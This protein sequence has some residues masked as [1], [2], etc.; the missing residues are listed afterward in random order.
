M[1]GTIKLATFAIRV[2]PPKITKPVTIARISPVYAGLS[3]VVVSID[4]E[5]VLAWTELKISA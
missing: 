4:R 3:P 2:M 1:N 5:I